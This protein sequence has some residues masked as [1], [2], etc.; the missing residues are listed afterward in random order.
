[1]V[2]II[3]GQCCSVHCKKIPIIVH[4]NLIIVE[5]KECLNVIKGS[6]VLSSLSSEESTTEQKKWRG[7][8]CLFLSGS[9]PPG[10]TNSKSCVRKQTFGRNNGEGCGLGRRGGWNWRRRSSYSAGTS[11]MADGAPAT[12]ARGG[13]PAAAAQKGRAGPPATAARGGA[14]AAAVRGGAP[15]GRGLLQRRRQWGSPTV[16]AGVLVWHLWNCAQG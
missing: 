10:A 14:P 6:V 13:A 15:V 5:A 4:T 2:N 16:P 7:M 8:L 1:M 9:R 3:K 12:A 11:W